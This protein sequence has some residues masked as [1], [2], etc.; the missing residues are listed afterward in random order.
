MRTMRVLMASL[1]V[2]A[3]AGCV[4]PPQTNTVAA[5]APGR[6]GVSAVWGPWAGDPLPHLLVTLWHESGNAV[7][8][9][10]SADAITVTGPGGVIPLN[11]GSMMGA[12]VLQGSDSV[13]I[14]LH[15]RADAAG[16]FT[17]SMDHAWGTPKAAAPGM[18]FVC[19][20]SDCGSASL[21]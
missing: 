7:A 4:A 20:A 11:W 6:L 15:P 5:T 13:S 9:G 19:V 3:L 12:N 17:F 10:P 18:Y 21:G 2:V 1:L 8:V 16:N 14:A